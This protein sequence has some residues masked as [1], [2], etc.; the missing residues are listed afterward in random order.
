MDAKTIVILVLAGVGGLI[1][2][3]CGGMMLL[4]LPAVQQARTAARTTQSRN[5]LKQIGLALHN[6]HDAYSLFPPGGVY[7]ADGTPHHSWQTVILPYVNQAG[8]YNRINFNQPWTDPVNQGIFRTM[9]PTYVHPEQPQMMSPAGVALSH[10]AGNKHVLFENSSTTIKS[11]TDGTSNTMLAGEVAGG[12]KG[13]GD[14]SNVRDPADGVL[15]DNNTFGGNAPARGTFQ[16]LL[17]DGSVRDVSVG[18]SKDV[19]KALATP[20]GGEPPPTF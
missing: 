6:Y 15:G 5:N 8:L 19:L 14:P 3:G 2:L 11:I 18:I 13:W 9:I 20:D 7:A 17:G 12:F 4:L 10:Y 1:L 16:I